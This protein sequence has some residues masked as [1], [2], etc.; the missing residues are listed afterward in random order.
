MPLFMSKPLANAGGNCW[1]EEETESGVVGK[2]EAVDEAVEEGG[3]TTPNGKD[4]VVA[5]PEK[6][7]KCERNIINKFP[8]P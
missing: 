1:T 4:E 8:F 5:A 3:F 7:K 6:V 2:G